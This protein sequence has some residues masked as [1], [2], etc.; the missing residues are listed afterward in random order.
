M[1]L[2]IIL[3]RAGLSLDVRELKKSGRSA[4]MMCFIP[5][6]C[7]IIGA[8]IF[9]PLLLGITHTEAALAGSVLAA[10]SPAV[11]VPGMLR[12]IEENRGTD[13]QIPQIIMAGASADDVYV[14]VLYTAFLSILTRGHAT[15][16][17][18]LQIPTSILL[19]IVM[20]IIFG[21][22]LSIVFKKIRTDPVAKVIITFCVSLFMV[23]IEEM[24]KSLIHKSG[25]IGVMA[26]GMTIFLKNKPAAREL[27]GKYNS[28]WKIAEI[29]LFVLVGAAVDINAA[30]SNGIAVLILFLI[31]LLFRMAGVFIC[32]IKTRLNLKE[33]LFCMLAYCPKATVQAAIGAEA[34]GAG[35]SCGNVILCMAVLAILITAP[36]GAFLIERTKGKLLNKNSPG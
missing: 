4:V 5:A 3:S 9:V 10:V 6:S 11:V 27:S 12:L 36:L 30:V 7:E 20:G 25:L 26:M 17:E 29:V 33:R 1:A 32:F 35:L 16:L 8:V 13:K 19:G 22:I 21:L 34:L 2:I 31:C 18:F 28:I 15:A 24:G 14:I 23:Y